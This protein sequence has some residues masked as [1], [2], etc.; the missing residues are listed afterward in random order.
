VPLT[1]RIPGW[2]I[3]QRDANGRRVF[4]ED[5][6]KADIVRLIF[7]QTI[8]GLGRRTIVKD[9][10]RKGE[11]SF[12]SHTAWQPSSVIK[13]IRSRTTVGEYQPHRRDK[14]GELIPDGDPIKR[15]YPAVVDESLWV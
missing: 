12:L 2:L 11:L 3:S 1:D 15:Y 6:Q 13:I 14:D 10:N 9:L 8:Q 5:K 4:T 7:A